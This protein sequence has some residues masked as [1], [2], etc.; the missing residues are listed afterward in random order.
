MT[1]PTPGW[2]WLSFADETGFL[3]GSLVWADNFLEAHLEATRLGLNPGGEVLGTGPIPTEAV[4]PDFTPN[5]LLQRGGQE[6]PTFVQTKQRELAAQQNRKRPDEVARVGDAMYADVVGQDAGVRVWEAFID[7][8]PKGKRKEAVARATRGFAGM[9]AE[10]LVD[11]DEA[12]EG[13]A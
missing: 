8:L 3:G 5:R 11:D 2:W 9:L 7:K 1:D 10:Y 12:E 13:S 4:P 6:A